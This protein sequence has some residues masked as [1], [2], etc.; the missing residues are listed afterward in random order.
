MQQGQQHAALH[1][2]SGL[3]TSARAGPDIVAFSD[4][5]ACAIYLAVG[6][7]GST[8]AE[9]S[10]LAHEMVRHAQTMAT[11]RFDCLAEREREGGPA[12]ERSHFLY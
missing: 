6:W 11:R 10:V 1:Q 7:T 12:G 8:P 5:S 9:L 4:P 2:Q 3:G